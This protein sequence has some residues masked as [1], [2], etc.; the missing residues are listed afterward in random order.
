MLAKA[1]L[2]LGVKHVAFALARRGGA[3]GRFAAKLIGEKAGIKEDDPDFNKKVEALTETD[4]G[5][6]VLAEI[7]LELQREIMSTQ[8]EITKSHLDY[9]TTI[10]T[11]DNERIMEEIRSTDIYVKRTRP[12]IVRGIFYMVCFLIGF[13]FLCFLADLVTGKDTYL[14]SFTNFVKGMWFM[15]STLVAVIPTYCG[16]RS[17]EKRHG[18]SGDKVFSKENVIDFANYVKIKSS[19]NFQGEQLEWEERKVHDDGFVEA[20]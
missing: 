7:N 9:F 19:K 13:A 1:L 12:Y 5:R 8:V 3:I 17:W 20:Q 6:A 18:T 15:L 11:S 16:V 14:D 10:S 4:Q 2:K